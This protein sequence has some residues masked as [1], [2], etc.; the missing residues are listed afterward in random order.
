MNY[1]DRIIRKR[2]LNIENSLAR[3]QQIMQQV[4]Q[5]YQANVEAQLLAQQ[6][7]SQ[8]QLKNGSEY[9]NS[10]DPQKEEENRMIADN[11]I[12]AVDS[13]KF[14]E[15][16]II[17]I[18]RGDYFTDYPVVSQDK[19]GGELNLT[20]W[21]ALNNIEYTA[22]PD[23]TFTRDKTGAGSIEYFSSQHPEGIIYPNGYHREHPIPGKDVI[24]Y[25]PNENDEQDIRLDALHIMPK[26][27]IYDTLNLLYRE[28][29]KD[30]D[31]FYNAKQKYEEDL[32]QF[33]ED[34]ID[35]FDD[36]FNNEADGLLRNM[37]I[38][39]SPEYIESKRYYPNKEQLKR[40]NPQLM[41]YI[42]NIQQYLESGRK[43]DW[44]L[45][46]ITVTQ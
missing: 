33:G 43:P 1:T 32:K 42:N 13:N 18:Q 23:T 15:A 2:A 21:K 6:N 28:A 7:Q 19:D 46:T 29:A 9:Y 37:F 17:P 14:D 36:Y 30:S 11:Y 35:T 39:G 45:P 12:G 31:V 24:L 26:D 34:N 40:W 3:L 25:N 20:P 27:D 8:I 41:P 38:Q 10:V 22:I 4:E 44:L 16:G 5:E